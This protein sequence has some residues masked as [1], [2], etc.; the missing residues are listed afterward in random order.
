MGQILKNPLCIFTNSGTAKL[1]KTDTFE[2]SLFKTWVFFKKVLAIFQKI[3]IIT[4]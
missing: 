1:S 3:Y 2:Q 4:P